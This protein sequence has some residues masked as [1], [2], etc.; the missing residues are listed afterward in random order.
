MARACVAWLENPAKQTADGERAAA[1][2]RARFTVEAGM[3][4]L[5]DELR[6]L[7][8]PG[9][10]SPLYPAS[11]GLAEI[12]AG[13]NLDEAPQAASVAALLERTRTLQ[14]A[15]ALAREGRRTEAIK[16]MLHAVNAD[17]ARKDAQILL[18]SLT[19]VAA[20]LA[21]LE[22]RQAAFLREQADALVRES[23]QPAAA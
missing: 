13:W 9:R 18:D 16:L 1:T 21:P 4:A 6:G 5:W 12:Y 23:R 17:L 15:D 11:A 7:T 2:V 19:E 20:R 3:P 8:T 14:K 22:P 10:L